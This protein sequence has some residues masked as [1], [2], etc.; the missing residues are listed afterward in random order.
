M[1]A[2]LQAGLGPGT[3]VEVT[4]AGTSASVGRHVHPIVAGQLTAMG[5][6]VPRAVA[7][8]LT[9]SLL[10]EADLVL[11]AERAHRSAVVRLRP[12]VVR[13]TFT[14]LEFAELAVLA[15]AAA[16]LAGPPARRL[17]WL[18]DRAPHH[19][20]ERAGAEDDIEDPFGRDQAAFEVAAER[21]RTAVAPVVR[22]VLAR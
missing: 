14:L 20:P 3:G 1:A 17:A 21:I 10:D 11:T 22:T 5:L 2:V 15:S 19:R 6:D 12:R 16:Q 8:Q 18:V 4:S 9:G 13:R 7:R